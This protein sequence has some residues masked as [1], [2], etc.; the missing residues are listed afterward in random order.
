[1]VAVP[2]TP[3]LRASRYSAL[4]WAFRGSHRLLKEFPPAA[5]LSAPSTPQPRSAT[6]HR[7]RAQ[8]I[9]A[10][11]SRDPLPAPPSALRP[12]RLDIDGVAAARPASDGNGRRM[13]F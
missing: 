13:P 1:M 6:V 9:S 7:P 11:R 10:L 8:P 4:L 3:T 2:P 5:T 12:S